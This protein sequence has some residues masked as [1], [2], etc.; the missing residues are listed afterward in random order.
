[1]TDK[2]FID[3]IQNISTERLFEELEYF[4]CD[5]YYKD[6]WRATLNELKRRFKE[7]HNEMS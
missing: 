4:G 2:E 6:L 1:M 5:G 3:S 7:N